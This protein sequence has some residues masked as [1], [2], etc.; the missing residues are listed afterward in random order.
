M[1]KKIDARLPKKNGTGVYES[2]AAIRSPWEK[3][4]QNFINF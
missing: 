3:L 2:Y 4:V 1:S